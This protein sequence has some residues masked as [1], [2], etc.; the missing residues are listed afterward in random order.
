MFEVGHSSRGL[1]HVKIN[2]FT[3]LWA[4]GSLLIPQ[5]SIL[6]RDLFLVA[7]VEQRSFHG[8][9]SYPAY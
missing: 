3:A 2:R 7:K 1:L 8:S 6:R 9:P 5:G 4:K